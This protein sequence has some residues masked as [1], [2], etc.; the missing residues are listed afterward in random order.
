MKIMKSNKIKKILSLVCI[1]CIVMMS[2]SFA[3]NEKK[4]AKVIDKMSKT[5]DVSVYFPN[6][7]I[8]N[9]A[10]IIEVQNNSGDK[11]VLDIPREI[12]L[13]KSKS[14]EIKLKKNGVL[15]DRIIIEKSGKYVININ[16]AD[17]LSK[18]FYINISEVG[19]FYG[20]NQEINEVNFSNVVSSRTEVIDTGQVSVDKID[21]NNKLSDIYFGESL[22]SNVL[23]ADATIS[24]V[25]IETMNIDT[26]VTTP[27]V[28]EKIFFGE[29]AKCFMGLT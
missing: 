1:L 15:K 5:L 29:G 27:K 21:T 26:K 22:R 10:S 14:K 4:D 13:S 28:K 19:T 9:K 11:L 2:F 7:I 3:D 23:S 17:G 25:K 20:E 24:H 8:L 18:K 12:K 6:G 16:S